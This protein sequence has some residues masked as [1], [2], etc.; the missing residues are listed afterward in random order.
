MLH[1]YINK[2]YKNSF[3]NNLKS[4][5]VDKVVIRPLLFINAPEFIELIQ[6]IRAS[7]APIT[8]E[9]KKKYPDLTHDE[10]ITRLLPSVNRVVATHIA[11]YNHEGAR[12]PGR[13]SS[14]DLRR[15]YCSIMWQTVGSKMKPMISQNA[16]IS[17]ILGHSASDL[18]TASS[19]TTLHVQM[20]ETRPA[21]LPDPENVSRE[22]QN[23]PEQ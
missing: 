9:Y 1:N 16:F 19:Y 8:V 11:V 14:H 10:I 7:I 18:G 6:S 20:P 5:T 12:I 21:I 4:K 17:S 15:I 23:S 3:A 2:K 13:L 22:V